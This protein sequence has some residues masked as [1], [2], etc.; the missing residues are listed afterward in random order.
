[1]CKLVCCE[2]DFI[3][4]HTG[5]KTWRNGCLVKLTLSRQWLVIKKNVFLSR[6]GRAPLGGRRIYSPLILKRKRRNLWS[7]KGESVFR[8]WKKLF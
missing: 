3:A 5:N 6:M 8:D 7:P 4:M 1:M 2:E